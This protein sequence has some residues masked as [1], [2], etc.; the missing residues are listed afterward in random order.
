MYIKSETTLYVKLISL[1]LHSVVKLILLT[2]HS[3]VS[4]QLVMVTMTSDSSSYFIV[5]PATPIKP[6]VSHM[7]RGEVHACSFIIIIVIVFSPYTS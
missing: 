2:L 5:I 4:D 3:V 6:I 7:S 1:T